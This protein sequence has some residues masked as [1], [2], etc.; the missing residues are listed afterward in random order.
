MR[1]RSQVGSLRLGVP[2]GQ[3]WKLNFIATLRHNAYFDDGDAG[4]ARAAFNAGNGE[5]LAFVLPPDHFDLT[6][7][8]ET[9]FNRRGYTVT[10][11]LSATVRSDWE[12]WGLVDTVSGRPG[13]VETAP[14]GSA[15]FVPGEPEPVYDSHAKWGVQLFKEWFL[16]HFQ[17][18]RFSIN[19]LDGQ[20]LDRF[21]QY[22]FS[23]FGDDRL[24]GFSGSGVRF[25]QGLIGRIGYTFNLFK[26]VQFDA[27]L[28]RATV[29]DLRAGRGAQSFLGAGFSGSVVGPWKS[30]FS[31]NY[32]YA[33][34]SDIP[35]LEGQQEFLLLIFKL[36]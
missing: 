10:V 13:S 29:E 4:A 33:L 9:L 28:E 32:G 25:D 27:A 31:F 3:F 17:K 18:A 23:F 20:D 7:R 34:N 19:L 15:F 6:G 11:D 14:D 26:A 16:P 1:T 2:A 35:E 21:S 12:E 30:V 8:W 36:F 24:F 5:Q 22:R